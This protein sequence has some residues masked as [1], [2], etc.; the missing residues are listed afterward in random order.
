MWVQHPIGACVTL[1]FIIISV[2]GFSGYYLVDM[3]KVN[4]PSVHVKGYTLAAET[5]MIQIK[6]VTKNCCQGSADIYIYK[7]KINLLQ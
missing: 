1:N 5:S 3:H 6:L 2:P 7:V 4:Q